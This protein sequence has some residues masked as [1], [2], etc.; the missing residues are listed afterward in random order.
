MTRLDPVTSS[1]MLG[2]ATTFRPGPLRGELTV[3]GDKSISHRAL[4]VGAALAAHGERL[5]VTH[6]NPGRDVRA[7]LE[8]LLA[9]G[10]QIERDS[11]DVEVSGGRLRESAAPIDCM[12][13]GSTARMLLGVC[14]G[15]NVPAT[16]DGDESAR[17]RPMEPVAAQLRAFGAKSKPAKDACRFVCRTPAIE[18]LNFILLT[19]VGAGEK[20]AAVCRRVLADCNQDRRRFALARSYRTHAAS[21]RLERDVGRPHDFARRFANP[22][23]DPIDPSR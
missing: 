12:N 4:I 16:F 9:L 2:D 19:P 11:D 8:A 14:A 1:S 10:V 6:L 3:P 15:A 20:R 7:T 5:R 21:A 13:S 18:T 22:K 23:H 17:R